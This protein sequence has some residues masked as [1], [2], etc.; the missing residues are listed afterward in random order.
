VKILPPR[1]ARHT[2]VQRFDHPPADVF[3]L[4]CPVRE[5]EYAEGW[6]PELVVSASG[7]AELGCAFV[8]RDGRDRS[9]WIVTRYE[10]ADGRIAMVRVTPG[11]TVC[12]LDFAVEPRGAGGTDLSITYT[13]TSIGP[14]GDARVAAFDGAAWSEFMATWER[15]MRGQLERTSG[16]S[17]PM[18]ATP[19]SS[20][21][22]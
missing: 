16:Y 7:V 10:P 6:D 21:P 8:T 22:R 13:L 1:R 17:S 11:I 9:Y 20:K 14:E 12:Q 15:E 4:L 2:R 19:S 18:S 3:P 5:V